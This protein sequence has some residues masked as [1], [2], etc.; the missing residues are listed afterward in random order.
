R[1]QLKDTPTVWIVNVLMAFRLAWLIPLSSILRERLSSNVLVA[2]LIVWIA[3]A[4]FLLGFNG[5]VVR[6]AS[7]LWPALLFPMALGER[8]PLSLLIVTACN[9][10][11][12]YFFL[13]SDTS[14]QFN[15]PLP[16]TLWRVFR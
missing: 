3:G 12:P 8:L 15:F 4:M 11:L 13:G 1:G 2:L 6:G 9:F 14:F 7:F 16:L 5:D 10:I